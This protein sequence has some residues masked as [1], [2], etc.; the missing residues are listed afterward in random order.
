[1]G[2]LNWAYNSTYG[3]FG[4]T[5]SDVKTGF[6][7]NLP[8]ICSKYSTALNAGITNVSDKE[9]GTNTSGG[10]STSYIIVKD[11]SYGTDAT[12]FKTAMNGV[13]LAYELATPTTETADP[14][15]A[16]QI[17][18]SDGTEA[19]TDAL[20]EAGTRD[21]AIPAG[22]ETTYFEDMAG[23]LAELPPIPS[24]PSANGTYT[25]KAVVSSG[26]VTYSWQS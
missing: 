14:Y 25:L 2:T 4:A 11:S 21:V 10:A 16:I 12:A 20:V 6:Y 23:K 24:A 8:L 19:F 18:D 3:Y 22:T 13:K 1:M 26:S 5:I 9:I 7:N 15:T 17:C